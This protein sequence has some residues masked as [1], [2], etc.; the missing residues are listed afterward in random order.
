MLIVRVVVESQWREWAI[1]T[2][3][4]SRLSFKEGR[5]GLVRAIL[6]ETTWHILLG[7]KL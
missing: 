2:R 7:L 1:E 6:L 3:A 5:T 4:M